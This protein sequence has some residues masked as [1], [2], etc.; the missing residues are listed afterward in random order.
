M[1]Q[2]RLHTSRPASGQEEEQCNSLPFFTSAAAVCSLFFSFTFLA[3]GSA[4]QRDLLRLPRFTFRLVPDRFISVFNKNL[5]QNII[6][7]GLF[8]LSYF[9]AEQDDAFSEDAI[10]LWQ[11]CAVQLFS[12]RCLGL[13]GLMASAILV[14]RL[15]IMHSVLSGEYVSDFKT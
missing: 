3:V 4:F 8:L 5:T 12:C 11:I 6:F 14:V 7:L 15:G 2:L 13:L 10:P 9:S 1:P